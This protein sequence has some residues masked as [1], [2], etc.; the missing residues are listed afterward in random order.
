MIHGLLMAV[1]LAASPQATTYKMSGTVVREDKQDPSAAATQA[2]QVR[3]SGPST[4]IVTIGAGGTFTFP[5]VRPGT[6]QLVVGPRI[7]MSPMTV[8]V[9]DKD[10]ADLRVVIPLSADVAG[11][12]TVEGN[13]PRPR[14]QI[15]FTRVDVTGGNPINALASPTFTTSMAVGEYKMSV[16]GLPA[17]YS[18]KSATI[19]TAD[20]LNQ[21]FKVAPGSPTA[22]AIILGVSSPP[23]WVKVS[24]RVIGGVASSVSMSGTATLEALTAPV[25]RDGQFEF[26]MVLP[27]TYTARTVPAVVLAPITS[28]TVGTSD[29]GNVELRIPPTWEVSGK[30]TVRGNV[31][32]PRVI[33]SL[34]N[35]AAT[36]NFVQGVAST[37]G[38]VSVPTNVGPDGTF[39][40]ILPEGERTISILPTSLPTG[41]AVDSFTY[42]AVDLLKNPIRVALNDTATI[43]IA[44]DATTVKPHTISGKVTGLLTTQGVR[45]VLQGGNLGTGVE[46]PVAPDGS[47]GFTDIFPGNYSARLS[48][49]GHV[50]SAAVNVGNND[51]ANLV[52]N[53]PRLF[54][55]GAHVLVEGAGDNSI[56]PAITLEAR[57]AAGSVIASSG[58]STPLVLTIPDGEHRI[59]V[60]S[61][62][63]GYTLK[64]MQYGTIDLQKAPLKVDGPI[65]W[66]IVVRLEKAR[67]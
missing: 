7:T 26:P 34:A 66:E 20:A 33:F 18:L 60:R 3:I 40:V 27:G 39:K 49:S 50:I 2:N 43:A 37:T 25:G 61:L 62:P 41:Y 67:P 30:I 13:G 12:V 21:S 14:F 5:S 4:M 16:N 9:T 28:I 10:V 31:P 8:V 23:P 64:S 15:V 54:S 57:S 36:P 58:S 53:Y 55:I 63:P 19:G 38:N 48:L 29:L 42:G 51:V 44:V 32:V 65:T 17:G 24:G 1:L 11:T 46:S 59:S 6:Y 35:A 56:V 45:V 22:L 52:I 47:F